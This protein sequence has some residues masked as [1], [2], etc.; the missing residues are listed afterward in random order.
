M[1]YGKEVIHFLEMMMCR[2]KYKK[3]DSKY[4][5]CIAKQLNQLVVSLSKSYLF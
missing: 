3:S 5:L 4:V 1:I 2:F